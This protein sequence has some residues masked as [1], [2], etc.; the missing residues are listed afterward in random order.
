MLFALAALTRSMPMFFVAPAALMHVAFASNRRLAVRQALALVMGFALVAGPYVVLLSLEMGRFTP[1]D[2]HGSLGLLRTV[3]YSGGGTPSL[4]ETLGLL[5]RAIADDPGTYFANLL[6]RMKA[7]FHVNGGR[8]LEIFIVPETK[9]GAW[10]WK[11]ALHVGLDLPLVLACI[12]AP[13]GLVLVRHKPAAVVL[14]SWAVLNLVVSTMYGFGTPRF[15]APFEFALFAFAAVVV[16]GGWQPARWFWWLPALALSGVLA[17]TLLP[18]LPRSLNSYPDY[19][20]RWPDIILRRTGEATGRAGF[21]V[22]AYLGRAE[23]WIS[24]PA[25]PGA[26]DRSVRVDVRAGNVTIDTLTLEPGVER[27]V[28]FVWPPRR[29]AYVEINATDARGQPATVAITV[30]PR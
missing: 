19:G 4:V 16:S 13:I 15:R 21:N 30:P 27:H 18:Q 22:P 26:V 5:A 10:A 1:I 2:S 20:V 17:F 14:A 28:D 29:F 25:P 12:L 9:T 24:N 11:G 3:S 6:A 7:V 8:M 23:V